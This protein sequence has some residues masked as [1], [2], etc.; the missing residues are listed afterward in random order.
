MTIR[1]PV[2]G[3]GEPLADRFRNA[4]VHV[5]GFA[6]L[7]LPFIP[8]TSLPHEILHNWWGNG[9]WVDYAGGN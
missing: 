4:V 8:Y 6:V 3:C 1:T 2:R 7:R 9:V 5:A